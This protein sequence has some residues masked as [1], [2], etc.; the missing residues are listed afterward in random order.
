MNCRFVCDCE[1]IQ[2]NIVTVLH[3]ILKL[4]DIL[5]NKPIYLHRES[6]SSQI[7]EKIV[8][9][10]AESQSLSEQLINGF[11]HL[12]LNLILFN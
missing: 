12:D 9:G 10:L 1:H 7:Q 6:I 8:F 5:R 4:Q 3:I 2:N 11:N